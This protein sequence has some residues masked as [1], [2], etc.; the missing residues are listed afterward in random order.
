MI[1][2]SQA[3]TGVKYIPGDYATLTAAFTALNTNGVGTGGVEFRVATDSVF[4]ERPPILT[5]K[6][7]ASNPIVFKRY[8]NG[9]NPIIIP[10]SAGSLSPT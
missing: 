3:L 9:K 2:V 7:T 6:G 4:Y 5:A 8:G 10:D 1:A